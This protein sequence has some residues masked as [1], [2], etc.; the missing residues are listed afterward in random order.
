MKKLCVLTMALAV[1]MLLASPVMATKSRLTAMGGVDNYLEDDYNIFNWPATLPSYA[2]IVVIELI[3]DDYY[4]SGFEPYA[5]QGDGYDAGWYG[6]KVSAMFGLIKG[7]G[8]ENQYGTL[9]LFLME[10]A[11]GLNPWGD[12]LEGMWDDANLFSWPVYNKFTLMYGYA[13]DGGL[14]F[15]LGFSRS[16]EGATEELEGF[17]GEIH[18]AYT[19]LSAGVRFDIGDN[20]YG[21]V[22]FDYSM[23]SYTEKPSSYGEISQDANSMY[24]FKARAFYDWNEYLTI[25]PFFG[26]R[27]WDFSLDA[28]S[29][30]YYS[31]CWGSKGMSFNFGIGTNWMVN[32]EN[33]IIVG[34]DPYSYTKVEPSE[35][36]SGYEVEGTMTT[37]PR[38]LLALE[39]EVTDWL[40]LR[41]G[42]IKELNKLEMKSAYEDSEYKASY[43]EACFDW[44]LG[45][46]FDVADFEIDCVVH[47][48]VPFSLGYWLTGYQPYRDEET[49]VWMISAKYHF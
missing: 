11:S 35:C 40:T 2:N 34:I 46:G 33:T 12:E 19:T 49:P 45:L 25:I 28:D 22:A 9:G 44:F 8:E 27:M 37:L 39:S 17:D 31:E 20:A 5:R 21:D 4:H 1:A 38:F 18:W 14:S 3:N 23:A 24:G 16:D 48:Q 6:N 42:C 30:G 47:E 15:G 13:M 43:T 29:S 10:V 36:E 7:L 26:F 41:T 32:D